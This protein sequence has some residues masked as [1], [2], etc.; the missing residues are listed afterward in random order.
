MKVSDMRWNTDSVAR[1]VLKVEERI[2]HLYV[3]KPKPFHETQS[4][5]L[6][7]SFGYCPRPVT[8]YNKDHIEGFM[9]SHYNSYPT[10]TGWGQYST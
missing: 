2:S 10:V 3:P 7:V 8:V 1:Y 9:H 6:D 5:V 4:A